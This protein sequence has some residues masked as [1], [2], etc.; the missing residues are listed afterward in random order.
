MIDLIPPDNISAGPVLL[1]ERLPTRDSWPDVPCSTHPGRPTCHRR[2]EAHLLRTL[3]VDEGR[4]IAPGLGGGAREIGHKALDLF[5]RSRVMAWRETHTPTHTWSS[6]RNRLN[7]LGALK[8][9]PRA[10]KKGPG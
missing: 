8:N 7:M 3:E 4:A 5:W 10:H 9:G 2:H 6:L 1:F